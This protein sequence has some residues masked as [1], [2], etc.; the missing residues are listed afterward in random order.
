MP[1]DLKSLTKLKALVAMNNPWTTISS[2]VLASW[3][4]LNSL[5]EPAHPKRR[6][7]LT[8]V[9]SH[10]PNL[11][12]IPR[13][14]TLIH[15]SKI[16]F[17]HCPRI[18]PASIPSMSDLPVLRDVK[19]NNL[20]LL[21]TL[22]RSLQYWG[23]GPMSSLN[24]TDERKGQGLEV[25]DVGSCSLGEGTL[26]ML[27]KA[28]FPILRSLTLHHNPLDVARPKYAE[29]L[30]G[31]RNLPKLAIIDNK[32]VVE[33]VKKEGGEKKSKKKG[34]EV[35]GKPSGANTGGKGQMREWGSKR[36]EGEA[37]TGVPVHDD[38]AATSKGEAKMRE[39]EKKEKKRKRSGD[40]EEFTPVIEKKRSKKDGVERIKATAELTG[41]HDKRTQAKADARPTKERSGGGQAKTADPAP[42]AAVIAKVADP[43]ALTTATTKKH[44]KNETGVYGVVEVVGEAGPNKAK[45][46]GSKK[47]RDAGKEPGSSAAA[48]TKAHTGIDL[49]SLVAEKGDNGLGVDSW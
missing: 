10:S 21:T 39:G 11:I 48:K 25:L 29:E 17:S 18:T 5:S 15:L 3:P 36:A 7:E 23:T 12:A 41:G 46:K 1:D 9:I 34:R 20:P 49:K 33:R 27:K 8:V 24:P 35:K 16:T 31:L 30:Q 37:P 2:E 38:E 43:S 19:M 40:A 22:P 45:T 13:L 32:R 47:H 6:A 28:D 42:A 4:E 26:D 14:N 44:S